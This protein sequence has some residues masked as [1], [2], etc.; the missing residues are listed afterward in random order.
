MG[1]L[2]NYTHVIQ[3]AHTHTHTHTPDQTH[4]STNIW[5]KIE[6][7]IPAVK[8]QRILLY[9]DAPA[10]R[11]PNISIV[12]CYLT[13]FVSCCRPNEVASFSLMLFL[14]L[15][16]THG[17]FANQKVYPFIPIP[18][19]R[20]SVIK[21]TVFLHSPAPSLNSFNTYATHATRHGKN[22]STKQRTGSLYRL[23]TT[24]YPYTFD[25]FLLSDSFTD[26]CSSSSSSST[27]SAGCQFQIRHTSVIDEPGTL[28]LLLLD[29]EYG[30]RASRGETSGG[31]SSSSA[32]VAFVFVIV[33]HVHVGIASLHSRVAPH[34]HYITM[35]FPL[36]HLP[37]QR[38]N[39]FSMGSRT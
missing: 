9:K 15:T 26:S 2:I 6:Y 18:I 36:H 5:K 10:Y 16:H 31:T 21:V 3:I 28:L 14:S 38:S 32:I 7:Q 13:T 12:G 24:P 23:P 8:L 11:A 33:A 25:T 20:V 29:G 35:L 19:P 30:R 39:I 17:S 1:F 34:H 4:K 27:S 22:T 37:H